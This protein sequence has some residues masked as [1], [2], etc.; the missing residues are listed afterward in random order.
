M[1]TQNRKKI[2]FEPNQYRNFGLEKTSGIPVLNALILRFFQNAFIFLIG[3][4]LQKL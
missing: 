4:E 2:G 1:I 3:S